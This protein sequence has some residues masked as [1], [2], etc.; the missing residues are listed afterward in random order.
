[1]NEVRSGGTVTSLFAILSILSEDL[2]LP[3]PLTPPSVTPSDNIS[4]FSTE[5]RDDF[6]Q[7]PPT[8]QSRQQLE[9]D[10]PIPTLESNTSAST[11]FDLKTPKTEYA[12]YPNLDMAK[13]ANSSKGD[14]KM[15]SES[16]ASSA[17]STT[18]SVKGEATPQVLNS[19]ISSPL[20]TNSSSKDFIN[21]AESNTPKPPIIDSK[22]RSVHP[23][24]VAIA[25]SNTTLAVIP[26]D[27]FRNLSEKFPG[28]AAH[29]VQVI[30]TRFQRMTFLTLQR[31]LGLSNELLAIEKKVNEVAGTGL[32]QD[33][34]PSEL[35]ES[36]AWRLSH[37]FSDVNLPF[38]PIFE[39]PDFEGFGENFEIGG[40]LDKKLRDSTFECIAQIIGLKSSKNTKERERQESTSHFGSNIER[41]Y[42]STRKSSHYSA[43]VSTGAGSRHIPGVF[44]DG[45][46]VSS[47]SILDDASVIESGSDYGGENFPE[48]Q[49]L[50]YKQGKCLVKEGDRCAGLYFVLDGTLEVSTGKSDKQKGTMS[51][52]SSKK[53]LFRID[54]GGLAGYLAGL[55]GNASFVS[56]EAKSDCLVGLMPKKILDK[57][58]DKY[59]NVLLCLA[60]RLVHQLSPLVFH[61]DVAL[62][63]GQVNAGQVLCRQGNCI[64]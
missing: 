62:E 12:S 37:Q 64:F 19:P 41:F 48:I 52:A 44:D 31:Y 54:P 33:L 56:I 17:G 49:I 59:P 2:D 16:I 46:S 25:S 24:L 7:A 50:F 26:A 47:S 45:Q 63:W 22:P 61:I 35:I 21:T 57:Y 43:S 60:K 38:D 34:F 27:S 30:L 40:D 39:K 18:T 51:A 1:M 15:S 36:T 20:A 6:D 9:L 10:L 28:A 3:V 58:M 8:P 42:Y 13:K 32:P 11:S 55:T 5:S 29:M 53:R 14:S 23:H 4:P